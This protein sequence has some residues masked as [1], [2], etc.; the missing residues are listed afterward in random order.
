MPKLT[1]ITNRQREEAMRRGFAV[2]I[3]ESLPPKRPVGGFRNQRQVASQE[4]RRVEFSLLA[5]IALAA[6][7]PLVL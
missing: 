1:G 5:A 2:L 6:L 7:I 3:V 4:M